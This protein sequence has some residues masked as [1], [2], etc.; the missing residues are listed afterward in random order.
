MLNE[1]Q[2]QKMIA[3]KQVKKQKGATMIEYALVI[4]GISAIA[5]AVFAPTGAITSGITTFITTTMA[6]L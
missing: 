2:V 6:A 3:A 1:I 5:T 4:G